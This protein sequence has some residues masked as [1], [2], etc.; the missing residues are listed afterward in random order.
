MA[1]RH[2][3]QFDTGREG[4]S[5]RIPCMLFPVTKDVRRGEVREQ[6]DPPM[7]TKW[8]APCQ[9]AGGNEWQKVN[10]VG[11]RRRNCCTMIAEGNHAQTEI[12]CHLRPR[13]RGCPGPGA[14]RPPGSGY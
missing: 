4:M 9:P 2:A 13:L 14:A 5:C 8:T 7:I 12:L 1:S 11:P 6:R 10:A 3:A